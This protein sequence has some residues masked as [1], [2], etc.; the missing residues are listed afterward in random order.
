MARTKTKPDLSP[1][2]I[3]KNPFIEGLEIQAVKKS[4]TVI[5][6]FEKEDV[7]EFELEKVPYTKVFDVKGNRKD[8]NELPIRS[9]ELYLWLIH[10]IEPSQ[11]II[12]IDRVLYMSRMG[13]KSL[14]TYKEAI[15]VLCDNVYIYAHANP[16]FKEVYW[17]NPKFIFKGSRLNKY[18]NNIVVKADIKVK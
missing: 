17:I 2:K 10:V 14:N 11:D 1:E 7:R 5:N 15:K 13:I 16:A 8:V 4:F 6:K 18:P 9:K 3:G 12:W